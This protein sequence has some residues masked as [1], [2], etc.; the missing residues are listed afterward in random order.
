MNFINNKYSVKMTEILC[1]NVTGTISKMCYDEIVIVIAISLE[2]W[3][4]TLESVWNNKL[5]CNGE[6]NSGFSISSIE[7][8]YM[9][10]EYEEDIIRKIK[11]LGLD[12]FINEDIK[13]RFAICLNHW[14]KEI[15]NEWEENQDDEYL[16]KKLSHFIVQ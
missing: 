3:T 10:G 13:H 7:G 15:F 11:D 14:F 6:Y 5:Y 2:D 8:V 9:P 4:E 16:Q 1:S 12:K